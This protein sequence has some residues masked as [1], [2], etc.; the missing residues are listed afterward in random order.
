[1]DNTIFY[2]KLLDH[3]YDGVYFVDGDRRITF[4][5]NAAEKIT[6]YTQAEVLGRKCDDNILKHV[7][8]NGVNLCEDKCPLLESI[9]SGE[10]RK[11]ILYLHHKDGFRM[12]VHIRV[13]PM[14]DSEGQIIGA[15]ELFSDASSGIA[16]LEKMEELER[17]V[18][19]DPLTGL[20]NRRYIDKYLE[21][22]FRGWKMYGLNF[23]LILLD[24]DHFKAINDTYG[25]NAGDRALV[26]ISN[27]LKKNSRSSDFIGRLGGEEFIVIIRGGDKNEL[28]KIANRYRI[29][30]KESSLDD[31]IKVT[32][33]L[34]ATMM[35]KDDTIETLLHRADELM[36]KSKASGRDQVSI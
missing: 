4:W 12:P 21:E 34:G 13:V 5:N 2:K 30:I 23:G 3:L 26:M 9:Q 27:V 14:R 35:K 8:G 31:K 24:I 17:L 16:A 29:L 25:H 32:V 19:I 33:S 22:S 36:Y 20:A 1:M 18:L 28:Q 7:D 10:V 6:G 15:V 11:E